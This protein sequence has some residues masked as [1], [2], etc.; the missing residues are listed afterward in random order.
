VRRAWLMFA[1]AAF[2]LSIDIALVTQLIPGWA[3]WYSCDVNY[4]WQTDSLL[5]G[6]IALDVD[7]AN[8]KWDWAWWDGRA[9]QVWGLGTPLWRLPFEIGA[10]AVGMRAFPDRFVFVAALFATFYLLLQTFLGK[11]F[12]KAPLKFAKRRPA[13]IVAPLLLILHIPF[14]SLCRTRFLVYEEAQA[15]AYLFGLVL[16]A[17]T[18]RLVR[19]PTAYHYLCLGAAAGVGGFVRPTLAFYAVASLAVAS[20]TAAGHWRRAAYC[21]CAVVV[22]A[23]GWMFLALSNMDRFGA[24]LEFGHSLTVNGID[25]MRFASRFGDPFSEE[26][27]QSAAQELFGALFLAGNSFNGGEWYARDFFPG[28]SRTTRWREFYFSTYDLGM[29]GLVAFGWL[30][31]LRLAAKSGARVLTP[32]SLSPPLALALWSAIASVLLGAFY[33][34]CPFL[35]SRYLLDFGPAFAA[36]TVVAVFALSELASRKKTWARTPRLSAL[37]IGAAAVWWCYT[38]LSAE[39]LVEEPGRFPAAT[40]VANLRLNKLL[41]RFETSRKSRRPLPDVYAVGMP[42]LTSFN[43]NGAGWESASGQTRSAAVFFLK[44]SNAVEIELAG[45]PK[46]LTRADS[47]VRARIGQQELSLESTTLTERGRRLIFRWPRTQSPPSGVQLLF[48]G[49]V[50]PA[51]LFREFSR[52]RILQVRAFSLE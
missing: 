45:E 27:L 8:L 1:G 12:A 41:E 17:L 40:A 24:P 49:M 5:K 20:L 38:A 13:F 21:A 4:R 11:E 36:S 7:P 31:G 42:R 30:W 48:L 28:Q 3:R 2:F 10:R 15:Y 37:V 51:E 9:Q 26:P 25:Q 33:L 35:A 32:S 19:A 18:V 34:R 44:G 52:Y 43:Y 50:T 29:L 46:D 39:V 47:V 6:S 16:A 22:C 23:I 14:L